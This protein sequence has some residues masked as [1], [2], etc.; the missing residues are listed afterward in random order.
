MFQNVRK[1]ITTIN[2]I[3][4]LRTSAVLGF[5]DFFPQNPN[6]E[7]ALFGTLPT[8]PRSLDPRSSC[9]LQRPACQPI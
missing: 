9:G 3:L 6:T 4:I 5:K 2:Q 8:A 1:I 7:S